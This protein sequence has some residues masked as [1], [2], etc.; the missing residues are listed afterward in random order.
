M[1]HSLHSVRV[2]TRSDDVVCCLI[3]L[4]KNLCIV[5]TPG[6]IVGFWDGADVA[7][8]TK[9]CSVIYDV[10]GVGWMSYVGICGCNQ[11]ESVIDL[12]ASR[13]VHHVARKSLV[14]LTREQFCSY[15][16]VMLCDKDLLPGQPSFCGIG[17]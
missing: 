4:Y 14:Y 7:T 1:Q 9:K 6:D 3:F 16:H 13:Y 11:Q 5:E 8:V 17:Y 2:T 12:N 10:F 15:L